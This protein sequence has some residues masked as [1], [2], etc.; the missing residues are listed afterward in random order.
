MPVFAKMSAAAAWMSVFA[1]QMPDA[2]AWMS[3]FAAL[4]TSVAC[5]MRLSGASAMYYSAAAIHSEA[6]DVYIATQRFL[7]TPAIHRDFGK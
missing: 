1:A 3:A 2:A 6:L 7:L 5:Q 4:M